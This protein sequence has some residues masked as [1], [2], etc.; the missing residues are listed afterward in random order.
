M[1]KAIL[2]GKVDSASINVCNHHRSARNLGHGSH[3]QTNGTS[4]KNK[5]GTQRRQL[6]SPR[7]MNG[8]AQWLQQSAELQAEAVR[9]LVA[10]RRRVIDAVLQ[11]ALGMRKGF[12]A[13]AEFHAFAN[14]VAALFAPVTVSAGLS[15]F[16]SDLVADSEVGGFGADGHDD[17]C[18]LVTE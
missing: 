17:A 1:S 9:E 12:G 16:E 3:Q 14:V 8:N 2:D 7:G 4:A 13:A 10:P 5:N 6:R 15:H 18:R 11:R